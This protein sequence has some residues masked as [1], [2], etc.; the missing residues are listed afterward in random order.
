MTFQSVSKSIHVANL[1]SKMSLS[2]LF[3]TLTNALLKT[4]VIRMLHVATPKDLT[5][6]FV[7]EDLRE[8]EELTARV[9]FC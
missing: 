5:T 2:F 3:Q 6:A 1:T 7:R 9:K 4:N 8:T